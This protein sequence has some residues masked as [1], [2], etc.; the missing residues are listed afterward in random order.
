[1]SSIDPHPQ[2]NTIR[3]Q[4]KQ[5]MV[6]KD[7]PPQAW[8][9]IEPLLEIADFGKGDLLVRLRI[10]VPEKLT[11]EQRELLEKLGKSLPDPRQAAFGHA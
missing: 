5:N 3:L 10:V 6:L 4:L 1:M 8:A 11:K 7:M 2:R 9:D